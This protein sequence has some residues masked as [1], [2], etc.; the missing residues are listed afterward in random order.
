[1]HRDNPDVF[2]GLLW[3]VIF[4]FLK[5]SSLVNSWG[6]RIVDKAVWWSPVGGLRASSPKEL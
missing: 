5:Q 6:Y 1:M 2:W 3:L 4:K